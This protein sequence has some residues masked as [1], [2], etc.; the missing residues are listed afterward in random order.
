MESSP[1]QPPSLQ[2]MNPDKKLSITPAKQKAVVVK[3]IKPRL[4]EL[5][6]SDPALPPTLNTITSTD[7]DRTS[8]TNFSTLIDLLRDLRLK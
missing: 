2:T 7:N 5:L 6:T 1:F 8:S 3:A 4:L